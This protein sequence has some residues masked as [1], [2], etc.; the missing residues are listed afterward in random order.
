MNSAMYI[1][2]E[3]QK[4]ESKSIF[5]AKQLY[6]EKFI[7]KT[8]EV[9]YYKILERLTKSGFI[10]KLSRE[11]YYIP[12]DTKFGKVKPSEDEIITKILIEEKN[13]C[14]VG[15]RLYNKLGLTTQISKKRIFYCNTILETQ[16]KIGNLYFYRYEIDFNRE[17]VDTIEML[18]VLQN[19]DRIQDMNYKEFYNYC[20]DFSK[21][22]DNNVLINVISKI[23][24]KKSTLAFLEQILN[25]FKVD[26]TINK[27]LSRLSK[28]KIPEWKKI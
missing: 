2:N 21:K 15:Y 23:N 20:S 11:I 28:Y 3:F 25:H 22:Y 27:Y 17:N 16:K 10:G 1:K 13:G 24:Y 4:L 6:N 18:E 19:F 14:E 9:N 8:N 7:N 26:N 5:N 12:E